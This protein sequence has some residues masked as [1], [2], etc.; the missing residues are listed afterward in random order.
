MENANYKKDLE[1]KRLVSEM[2]YLESILEEKIFEDQPM[3]DDE[4]RGQAAKY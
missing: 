1:Y 3:I 2:Q 4:M